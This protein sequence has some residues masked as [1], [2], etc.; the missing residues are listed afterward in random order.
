MEEA[1]DRVANITVDSSQE[2]LLKIPVKTQ[3]FNVLTL[4]FPATAEE[5]AKSVE[6]DNFVRAMLDIRFTASNGGGSAVVFENRNVVDGRDTSG[7]IILHKLHP[8]PKINPVM[9]HLWGK[10]M[11]KWFG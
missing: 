3:A 11:A 5:S 7:K 4:M 2:S 9:L 8:I 6:W 1:E 10:I